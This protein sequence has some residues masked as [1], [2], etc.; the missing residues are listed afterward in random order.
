MDKAAPT[1]TKIPKETLDKLK[2][3]FKCVLC[4]CAEVLTVVLQLLVS[5][6]PEGVRKGL[7]PKPLD[8]QLVQ[9]R[10]LLPEE[11][12]RTNVLMF[13]AYSFAGGPSLFE[14]TVTCF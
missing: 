10:C 8:L 5:S 12:V 6:Q 11:I 2:N 13:G 14:P 3:E 4:Q 7:D 1:D 9:P